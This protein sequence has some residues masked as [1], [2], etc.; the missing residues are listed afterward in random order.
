M[1]KKTVNILGTEYTIEERTVEQDKVLEKCDA[2]CDK[3]SKEI[4]ISICDKDNCELH[5]PEWYRKKLIRHECI[6][7]F[8]FESGIHECAVW[9][10][11]DSHNEQFVD[12][13][14]IQFP[15]I[16]KVFQELDIL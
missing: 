8:L 13:I 5:N 9:T 16:L 4:I 6:H 3:T 15:K 14:A 7:A 10:T 12:W 1:E 2:Y 11:D